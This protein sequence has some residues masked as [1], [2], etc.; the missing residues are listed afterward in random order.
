MHHF[1]FQR[2]IKKACLL[3][4][5]CPP[6]LVAYLI[7]AYGVN[8]PYGDQWELVPL[9]KK[10]IEG[11]LSFNDLWAQHNEH[12]ILF[13]LLMMISL[14]SHSKWNIWWELYSNLS[15]ALFI[16]LLLYRLLVHTFTAE[17]ARW[18]FSIFLSVLVFSPIQWE[19]WLWGWQLPWFL[20]VLALL[21]AIH[22]LTSLGGWFGILVACVSA[23]V[24]TYSLGSGILIWLAGALILL[25]RNGWSKY[26]VI[27]LAAGTLT[28]AYYFM[29]YRKP[30][31][32]FLLYRR[33]HLHSS[34][35]RICRVYPAISGKC[36]IFIFSV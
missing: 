16:Y 25:C 6:I 36:L 26:T 22:A 30:P 3:A 18:L 29:D 31:R 34:S 11:S 13:P 1:T 15:I 2:F 21:M 20:N 7:Y 23:V 28:V 5:A 4:L 35:I 27:W 10:Y 32:D 33:S 9:L 14:A 17:S 24:G 12:R 19:N 8:I